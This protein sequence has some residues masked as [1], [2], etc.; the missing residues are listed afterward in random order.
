[1]NTSSTSQ[2]AVTLEMIGA[3]STRINPA[4]SR[5]SHSIRPVSA[6]AGTAASSPG[7][8]KES[9]QETFKATDRRFNAS[10]RPVTGTTLSAS[11]SESGYAAS[12][13][14]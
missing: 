5:G 1:M 7:R 2:I 8:R 4:K 6:W 9:G 14:P 10:C 3:S 11:L 13:A 12:A